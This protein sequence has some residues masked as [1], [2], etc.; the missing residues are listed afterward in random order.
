MIAVGSR[1]KQFNVKNRMR[2]DV[3]AFHTAAD[4]L[5]RISVLIQGVGAVR[6]DLLVLVRRGAC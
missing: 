1:S 6:E 2:G 3:G 4:R 5:M